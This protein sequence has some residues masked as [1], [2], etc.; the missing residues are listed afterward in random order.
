MALLIIRKR[1]KSENLKDI[2]M[3]SRQGDII[4]ILDD[5][6]FPGNK[7]INNQDYCFAFMAGTRKSLQYLTEPFISSSLRD[8][9][10][11]YLMISK[12]K[13]K[14]NKAVSNISSDFQN[15]TLIDLSDTEDKNG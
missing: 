7:I 11:D 15:P 8:M 13:F 5:G 6:Q 10:G 4:D 3:M 2:N 14:Y 1:D 12:R 9:A